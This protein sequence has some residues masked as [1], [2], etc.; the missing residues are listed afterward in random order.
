MK[1]AGHRVIKKLV[2]SVGLG[3][4]LAII[5]ILFAFGVAAVAV[6]GAVSSAS[7][8]VGGDL[9]EGLS[10]D[11]ERYRAMVTEYCSQCGIPDYVDLALAVMEQESHGQGLDPM[12]SSESGYNT[13]FPQR[14]GGITNAEYSVDVGVHTLAD[15]IR[16]AGVTSKEDIPL[17]S[18]ALQG[19]NF[20]NGYIPWAQERGGYTLE[21]AKEFSALQAASHGW[22]SYGDV[23]YVPHVLRYYPYGNVPATP[24]GYLTTPLTPGSYTIT[25]PFGYRTDPD[26]G[27]HNGIDMGAAMGTP[28]FASESGTVIFAA[29]GT[30]ANGY[31][32]YGNVVVIDHGNGYTTLYAHCEQLLTVSGATVS[33]GQKIALVGSTGN[34]TGYHCHFEVRQNGTPVDPAPY[35]DLQIGIR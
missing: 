14:P 28:I 13:M 29:M 31:N 9:Y 34:S 15:C 23:Q 19:Y 8:N 27:F 20:G 22:E 35:L 21:N 7:Q 18:L 3:W 12:Q 25:S 16:A 32:G 30:A 1:N 4:T 2:A 24:D 33:K 6:V 10:A 11:T 26:P 17:I 5:L